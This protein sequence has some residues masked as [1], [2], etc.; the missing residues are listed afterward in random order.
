MAAL[1][2]FLFLG[3]GIASL[4]GTTLLWPGTALDR[5]WA[6]NPRAYKE[7]FPFG[8]A[9]GILFFLLAAILVVAGVGWFKRRMWG[10]RL[11]AAIIATQILGDL[12]SALMGRVAEGATGVVIAG[13]I[14][15][16]LL[17]SETRAVFQNGNI[18]NVC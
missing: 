12:V 13:S 17:R 5:I 6:L 2:I 3:A 16:Y 4:A 9:V 1:G 10:W 14:L 11:A 15:L 7:L 18:S 8:R